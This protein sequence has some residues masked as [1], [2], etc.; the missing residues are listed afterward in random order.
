MELLDQLE[1]YDESER[2]KFDL[3]VAFQLGTV[4]ISDPIKPKAGPPPIRTPVVRTFNL[5]SRGH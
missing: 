2:T 4:V 1:E 3:A 5:R